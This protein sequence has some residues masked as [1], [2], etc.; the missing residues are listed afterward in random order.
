MLQGVLLL[1]FSGFALAL[2]GCGGG[3]D[4]APVQSVP[5]L[6]VPALAL[7]GPSTVACN[8]I[9]QDFSRLL[10]GEEAQDYWVGSPSANNTPRYVT[11]LLADPANTPSVVIAATNDANLY[12]S[13]A[14]QQ[15]EF[16][17][18]ACYPTVAANTRAD[19][20]LPT[21]DLMPHM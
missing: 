9:A 6:V 14:G 16:V 21:G 3:G 1:A 13:F 20:P 2:A 17:L 5:S 15:V 19:Y 8:N 7:P 10:P 11:D 18:F 4:T 12:G